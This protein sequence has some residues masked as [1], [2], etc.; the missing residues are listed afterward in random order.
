MAWEKRT[1]PKVPGHVDP[2]VSRGTERPY[3]LCPI[4][5]EKLMA[6]FPGENPHV[7]NV[8]FCDT[9][10]KAL[11]TDRCISC[12]DIFNPKCPD[13]DGNSDTN[14][15]ADNYS[16]TVI[17]PF[18]GIPTDCIEG[19]ELEEIYCERCGKVVGYAQCPEC[20]RIELRTCQHCGVQHCQSCH[21]GYG[22]CMDCT[23]HINTA[24]YEEEWE[25]E[26]KDP[27]GGEMHDID[28]CDNDFYV[29]GEVQKK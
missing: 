5:G 27:Y 3:S 23:D 20:R 7:C 24:P 25:V 22:M 9:C 15:S 1:L 14:D 26:S 19:E 17:C 2:G 16:D 28:W 4:H 10:G 6:P 12:M 29:E 8:Y 11:K 21:A 18:H 13:C